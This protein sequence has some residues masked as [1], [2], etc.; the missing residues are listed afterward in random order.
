LGSIAYGLYHLNTPNSYTHQFIGCGTVG[1][2]FVAM[3]IF[4]FVESKGKEMKDYLLTTENIEK[5]QKK[6]TEKKE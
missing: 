4:L 5:M 2:F 6:R 3:P 1:L